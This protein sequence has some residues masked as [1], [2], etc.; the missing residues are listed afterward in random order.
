MRAVLY[1]IIG[2][3]I[4]LGGASLIAAGL[5]DD[6]PTIPPTVSHNLETASGQSFVADQT[7]NYILSNQ[8]HD[9][10]NEIMPNIGTADCSDWENYSDITLTCFYW[11]Y[12]D[13]D[14]N[15]IKAQATYDI[16]NVGR[17]ILIKVTDLS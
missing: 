11:S 6:G 17:P 16:T 10:T 14:G 5:D 15:V 3:C 9:L 2:I 4:V 7:E 1:T 12:P 13:E 8:P